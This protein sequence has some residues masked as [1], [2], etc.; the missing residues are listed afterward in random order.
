MH[1][2]GQ[3]F[4]T[5]MQKLTLYDGAPATAKQVRRL[6][7]R[8]CPSSLPWF[9]PWNLL[10]RCTLYLKVNKAKISWTAFVANANDGTHQIRWRYDEVAVF[11]MP[12]F[13]KLRFFV[14]SI[15]SVKAKPRIMLLKLEERFCLFIVACLGT[16]RDSAHAS[17][18]VYFLHSFQHLVQEVLCIAHNWTICTSAAA[19]RTVATT[20]F[21]Q[22][23]SDNSSNSSNKIINSSYS[24][25]SITKTINNSVS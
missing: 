4:M 6:A 22:I 19:A 11:W 13:V 7:S 5:S 21:Q 15:S 18:W 17:A 10:Q 2:R 16:P 3:C 25:N 12:Q 8:L 14:V 9:G 20:D 24:S 23:V 1:T